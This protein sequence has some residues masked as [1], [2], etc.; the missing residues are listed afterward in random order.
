VSDVSGEAFYLRDEEDGRFWSPTPLPAGAASPYTTRHGFGY[1]VFEHDEAGIATELHTFVATDAPIK[2]MV[3]T[4]R[5]RSGRPRRLSVTGFFELVLGSYRPPNLPCIVTELDP[6][7]GGL[8]AR[9]PYSN[10]LS[11]RVAWIVAGVHRQRSPG[12]H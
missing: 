8:F 12:S 10:E 1:T 4:V 7:S 11:Q 2:F 3:F 5:N 9:N 6:A